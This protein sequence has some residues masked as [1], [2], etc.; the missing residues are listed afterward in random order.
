MS[1]VALFARTKE[2]A[3][4]SLHMWR[5]TR[6]R[7]TCSPSPLASSS[8]GGPP[9]VADGTVGVGSSGISLWHF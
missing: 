8:R 1:G 4:T 9:S 7:G 2:V 6:P 3:Y 5:S